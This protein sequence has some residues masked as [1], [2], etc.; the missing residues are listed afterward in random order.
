MR[1][2]RTWAYA[3][4]TVTA[5]L[6]GGAIAG[7]FWSIDARAAGRA[8]TVEAEKF[9]LVD[10]GG[11]QRAAL[12]VLANGLVDLSLQD[13]K[14]GNRATIGVEADGSTSIGLFDTKGYKVATL[15]QERDGHTGLL[16]YSPQGK[17]LASLTATPSGESALRLLDKTTGRVRAGMGVAA[18]G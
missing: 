5:G 4:L 15:G 18:T 12:Q 3:C 6:V 2:S 7:S 14:G 9:V 1:V 13:A 16:L 10:A 11:R 17:G 8:K